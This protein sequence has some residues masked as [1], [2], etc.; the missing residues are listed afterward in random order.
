MSADSHNDESTWLSAPLEELEAAPSSHHRTVSIDN[1]RNAEKQEQEQPGEGA[2]PLEP[3]PEAP[4]PSPHVA[5]P[6]GVDAEVA[7]LRGVDEELSLQLFLAE[8]QSSEQQALRNSIRARIDELHDEA[9]NYR[10]RHDEARSTSQSMRQEMKEWNGA[11]DLYFDWLARMNAADEA[12]NK[13]STLQSEVDAGPA[14]IL[15][16]KHRAHDAL[17]Q[18]RRH[19][20]RY[21]M[22][23]VCTQLGNFGAAELRS[24]STA[25]LEMN[26]PSLI[27]GAAKREKSLQEA[28][29]DADYRAEE[30]IRLESSHKTIAEQCLTEAVDLDTTKNEQLQKIE[31]A[32]REERAGLLRVKARLEAEAKEIEF[33]VKRGTNARGTTKMTSADIRLHD[34]VASQQDELKLQL[35]SFESLRNEKLQLER[36]AEEKNDSLNHGKIKSD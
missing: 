11:S 32:F 2:A 7:A 1:E 28:C 35:Q 9:T 21:I 18:L 29:N 26:I 6:S 36:E 23:S 30:S 5:E 25:M 14:N 34:K 4:K 12:R 33:H 15:K 13:I 19:L 10:R 16:A 3:L 24:S 22:S 8:Q 27:D 31:E 17:S 20:N